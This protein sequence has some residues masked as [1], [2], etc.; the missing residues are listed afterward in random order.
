MPRAAPASVRHIPATASPSGA[1]PGLARRRSSQAP[2]RR[3]SCKTASCCC[4]R[5]GVRWCRGP[6]TLGRIAAISRPAAPC[7]GYPSGLRSGGWMLKVPSLERHHF[8]LDRISSS[9]IASGATQS[10]TAYR[11]PGLLR[12]F[13]LRNER[14]ESDSS[15]THLALVGDMGR[16]HRVVE[17]RVQR[18]RD[19]RRRIRRIEEA[20]RSTGLQA[21]W[22]IRD[23]AVGIA[24][25][26]PGK[27]GI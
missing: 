6:T 14:K 26:V 5:R 10:R 18:G 17:H 23:V 12:R 1:P 25:L 9:V 27:R 13:A 22:N 16:D 3:W 24:I 7:P 21:G 8:A 19:I 11:R 2:P 4:S 15:S 20:A